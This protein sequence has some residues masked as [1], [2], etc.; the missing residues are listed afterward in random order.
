VK[1]DNLEIKKI[2]NT[3]SHSNILLN[4][5]SHSNIHA[6]V[7]KI[8]DN[9]LVSSFFANHGMTPLPFYKVIKEK[10]PMPYDFVNL[11]L[12]HDYEP[13]YESSVMPDSFNTS[14]VG[15]ESSLTNLRNYEMGLDLRG[16]SH[17]NYLEQK[18]VH[19]VLRS[20]VSPLKIFS[21]ERKL[22][23]NQENTK[24]VCED[25]GLVERYK[26]IDENYKKGNNTI[27]VEPPINNFFR[28]SFN[29]IQ[30][31]VD[32]LVEFMYMLQKD[33]KHKDS[34]FKSNTCKEV[35]DNILKLDH[36]QCF[37]KEIPVKSNKK[38]KGE[39]N[40]TIFFYC[41][42]KNSES[43][44]NHYC[45]SIFYK[46]VE[47][48]SKDKN[49]DKLYQTELERNC[50]IIMKT[51]A[52]ILVLLLK[53]SRRCDISQ[54]EYLCLRIIDMNAMRVFLNYLNKDFQDYSIIGSNKLFVYPYSPTL[55]SATQKFTDK[56][57]KCNKGVMDYVKNIQDEYDMFKDR[58]N[59]NYNDLHS[60]YW[61]GYKMV[62]NNTNSNNNNDNNNN[63]NKEKKERFDFSL[64][65]RHDGRSIYQKVYF[66]SKI[67]KLSLGIPSMT[68]TLHE[69]RDEVEVGSPE[70]HFYENAHFLNESGNTDDIVF[71]NCEELNELRARLLFNLLRVFQRAVNN[72][73]LRLRWVRY[74]KTYNILKKLIRSIWQ[75]KEL[76]LLGFKVLKELIKY[77]IFS[78]VP[79]DTLSFIYINIPQ[80]FL[81]NFVNGEYKHNEKKKKNEEE[82]VK[83]FNQNITQFWKENYL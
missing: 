39:I 8:S 2:L 70:D 80:K 14:F 53:F 19:H 81:D 75:L 63:S 15:K 57:S 56:L 21:S 23:D 59:K 27:I 64:L 12:S 69:E 65:L 34:N 79:A 18:S 82:I 11:G 17:Y 58:D 55:P 13:S 49:N 16:M 67:N 7:S 61:R 68:P 31:I 54:Y 77:E 40:N 60:E 20:P 6:P 71:T 74:Y 32:N 29:F 26:L 43:E 50:D 24:P 25:V 73:S 76:Q 48:F 42:K 4:T 45:P 5:S 1:T 28:N 35:Y 51:I 52:M 30:S 83:K 78:E 37:L 38:N 10:N 9:P 41:V 3:S 33:D 47:F 22:L 44:D 72:H 46:N 62:V 36:C 66:R